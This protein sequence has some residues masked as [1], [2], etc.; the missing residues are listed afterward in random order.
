MGFV[1]G[2]GALVETKLSH[3][4]DGLDQLEGLYGP[5]A[6]V[7]WPGI[8]FKR[9]EVCKYVPQTPW[10]VRQTWEDAMKEEGFVILHWL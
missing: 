6:K 5:L 3:C 2:L 8:Q 1:D 4:L 9:I 7:I 10:P